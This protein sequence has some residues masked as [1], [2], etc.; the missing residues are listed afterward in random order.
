M[1]ETEISLSTG[2]L[3]GSLFVATTMSFA[4]GVSVSA[5]IFVA[6]GAFANNGISASWE[7]AGRDPRSQT[8]TSMKTQERR[9]S[10]ARLRSLPTGKLRTHNL[11]SS[12]IGPPISQLDRAQKA[13]NDTNEQPL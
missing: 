3:A 4:S 10:P 2:G 11:V 5:V 12:P 1:P 6:S 13:Q 8:D 7:C 9:M